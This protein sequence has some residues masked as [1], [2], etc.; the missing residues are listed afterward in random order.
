MSDK[1]RKKP[2]APVSERLA[3][4]TTGY[5]FS[6]PIVNG[7]HCL[8][9]SFATARGYPR[10]RGRDSELQTCSRVVWEE[11]TGTVLTPAEHVL[12][13]CDNTACI[14]FR[15]LFLGDQTL[16]DA[17]RDA[18]GRQAR[19]E[20]SGGAKLTAVEAMAILADA[21]PNKEI[22][23]NYGVGPNQVRRIKRGEHWK[24]LGYLDG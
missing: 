23:A 5:D 1:H 22:A 16:N 8:L 13:H 2:R 3:R 20:K 18:K 14:E 21:R 24:H 15:H 12:H 7:S 19:G 4:A 11:T 9:C 6:T 10:M 17:D